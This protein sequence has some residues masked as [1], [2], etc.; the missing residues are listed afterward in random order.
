MQAARLP[1]PTGFGGQRVR[2]APRAPHPTA[3]VVRRQNGRCGAS[4]RR[5]LK[6]RK[7]SRSD[8]STTATQDEAR[9]SGR[10]QKGIPSQV[11][12]VWVFPGFLPPAT[13]FRSRA[14]LKRSAATSQN[15]PRARESA[16]SAGGRFL[17]CAKSPRPRR[18]CN[19]E[20]NCDCLCA[21][22]GR[23]QANSKLLPAPAARGTA[24]EDWTVVGVTRGVWPAVAG[25][26]VSDSDEEPGTEERRTNIGRSANYATCGAGKNTKVWWGIAS[27]RA[28]RGAQRSQIPETGTSSARRTQRTYHQ[29]RSRHQVGPQ[30]Q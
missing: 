2:M 22:C 27:R 15:R 19:W 23:C 9:R 1:S 13:S 29:A 26:A 5:S 21:V 30:P 16:R 10:K 6:R 8:S 3:V 25:E 24:S 11:L 20:K 4:H 7:W 14:E 18:R 12:D 28:S 17:R